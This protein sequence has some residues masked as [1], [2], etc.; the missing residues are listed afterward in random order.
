MTL[1]RHY[2]ITLFTN[3]PGECHPEEAVEYFTAMR[4]KALARITQNR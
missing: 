3:A 4:A 1:Q 2:E